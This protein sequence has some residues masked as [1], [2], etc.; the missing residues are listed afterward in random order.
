[1]N[2]DI[3]QEQRC[4]LLPC[5]HEADEV[6]FQHISKH[7]VKNLKH[8]LQKFRAKL[9]TYPTK[10]PTNNQTNTFSNRM[11]FWANTYLN[12]RFGKKKSILHL[13]SNKPPIFFIWIFLWAWFTQI[14][15]GEGTSDPWHPPFKMVKQ[16]HRPTKKPRCNALRAHIRRALR[17]SPNRRSLWLLSLNSSSSKRHNFVD[18]FMFLEQAFCLSSHIWLYDRLGLRQR[19]ASFKCCGY[20]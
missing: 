7:S 13:T 20:V 15:G 12:P 14:F 2:N 5:H 9:S 18:E 8:P 19:G 11:A 4:G 1:M 10:E 16:S 17:V 3:Q 6:V